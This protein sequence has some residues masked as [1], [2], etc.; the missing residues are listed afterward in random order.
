MLKDIQ[1]TYQ[2]ANGGSED[3]QITFLQGSEAKKRFRDNSK[4]NL[5][6]FLMDV[7]HWEELAFKTYGV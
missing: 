1:G 2:I 5:N 4:N 7:N 6:A 3:S